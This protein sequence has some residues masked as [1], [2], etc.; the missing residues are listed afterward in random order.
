MDFKLKKIPTI[1]YACFVLHNFCERHNIYINE[2]QVKTQMELLKANETQSKNL[3]ELIL[4]RAESEGEVIRKAIMTTL[5]KTFKYL[6]FTALV[7]NILLA[8]RNVSKCK[9]S[10]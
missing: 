6:H 9:Y 3:P 7:L 1:I 10:I 4:S 8:F 5:R 2:E